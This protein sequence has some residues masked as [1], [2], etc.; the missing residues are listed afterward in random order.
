MKGN[1]RVWKSIL[2]SSPEP[3]APCLECQLC[4]VWD[5]KN[6]IEMRWSVKMF[7][8]CLLREWNSALTPHPAVLIAVQLPTLACIVKRHGLV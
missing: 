8:A 3:V 1:Y 6:Y 2:L 5:I 7:A 4:G